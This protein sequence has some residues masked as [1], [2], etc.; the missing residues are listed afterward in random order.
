[1]PIPRDCN[2]AELSEPPVAKPRSHSSRTE[3]RK[4]LRRPSR[5]D[6]TVP[7]AINSASFALL[8]LRYEAASSTVRASGFGWG[9]GPAIAT[10]LPQQLARSVLTSPS[11]EVGGEVLDA[12]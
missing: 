12:S 4:N 8:I 3:R 9:R 6:G 11:K 7:P 1:M 10:L 5:Y 2:Q